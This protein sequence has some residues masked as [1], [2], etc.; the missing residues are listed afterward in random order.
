M[1]KQGKGFIAGVLT[2]LLVVSFCVTAF[3]A[4]QKQATLNYDNIKISLNGKEVVSTDANGNKVEPFIIDGTTY[5][6]VRA[7]ANALG[8]EVGW[9]QATKTVTLEKSEMTSNNDQLVPPGTYS[10]SDPAPLGTIQTVFVKS[11]CGDYSISMVVLESFRGDAAW[12]KIKAMNM[13]TEAAPTGKEYVLLKIRVSLNPVASGKTVHISDL[14]LKAYNSSN[15]SYDGYSVIKPEPK[16]S[17][18]LSVGKDIEGY[19]VFTVDQNDKSPKF[20]HGEKFY[21]IGGIWFSMT[22]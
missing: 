16:T 17:E 15:S 4:Y 7:V 12:Q 9:E 3:A 1:K 11:C 20:V 14:E 10:R 21:G 18:P 22:K 2:T 6:P 13:F 8:L 5:L 19:T